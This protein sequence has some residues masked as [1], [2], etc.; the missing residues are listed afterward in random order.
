MSED[1]RPTDRLDDTAAWPFAEDGA[2]EIVIRVS[3]YADD[4]ETPAAYQ[5]IVKHRDRR[6][7][8][9]VGI[10]SDPVT[11]LM[12]AIS[13]FYARAEDGWPD[14]QPH[15]EHREALL[16]RERSTDEVKAVPEEEDDEL[17]IEDML[18]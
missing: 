8:W 17:S 15:G 14:G 3:R 11:A 1:P 12:K 2:E 16:S 6:R 7:I 18:G 5:A 10:T 9:G 4:N 13:E